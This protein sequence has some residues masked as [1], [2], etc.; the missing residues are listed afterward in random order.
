MNAPPVPLPSFLQIE[1]VGQCNLRC[2]MCS[3]A[4]RKDGPPHGPP[5]FMPFETFVKLLDQFPNAEELQLQGL[6]EPMMHPRFFDMVVHATGRG[7]RV[8]TNTNLT[9][10]NSDRAERCVTSGLAALHVSLDGATAE[11]YERIRVRARFSRVLGNLQ[12]LVAACKRLHSSTPALRMVVVAMRQNLHEFPA[13][14]RLAH[15]FGIAT[16]FFQHL[17]HEY[18]ETNLPPQY[19]PMRTFVRRET[20]LSEDASRIERYFDETRRVADE[21]GIA[22]RLPSVRPRSHPAGT[23]GR[24]RCDWPWRGAYLDFRGRALPCCMVS[25]ADR[26]QL[27]N[28]VESGALPVWNGEAYQNFRKELS[29]ENP[30]EVCRSCSI[31]WGTF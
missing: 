19:L 29:S 31:Y 4:F 28:M 23:T 25:T 10:L 18:G 27:G 9:L 21:L 6:G 15:R 5:A 13:L 26:I 22:V 1:P 24:E 8:S 14:V 11:T 16:I 20:L 3:I 7:V 2:Q 30:P 12:L 17:C